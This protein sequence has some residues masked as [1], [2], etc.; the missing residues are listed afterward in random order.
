MRIFIFYAGSFGEKVIGNLVN[1]RNFCA[2][3]GDT[4]VYCRDVPSLCYGGN[5]IGIYEFRGGLP[6]YIDDVSRYLPESLPAHDVTIV[7]NA[8]PDILMAIPELAAKAGSSALIVPVEEPRWMSPGLRQQLSEKCAKLSLEFAAPKPFCALTGEGGTTI[9]KFVREF[10]IGRPKIE[11]EVHG[12]EITAARVLCSA[13]CGST[14]F[15]AQKLRRKSAKDEGA[16]NE[17][18][19]GAHHAYPCTASMER[20]AELKDTILHK[21]GYIIREEVWRGVAEVCEGA[22]ERKNKQ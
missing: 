13:P 14:Y 1:F 15:V 16:L 21:A 4:C 10:R 22:K 11:V 8:H 17:V 12:G 9:G 7:I 3:C 6:S 20:D 2:S 5:I 18:I 19:S